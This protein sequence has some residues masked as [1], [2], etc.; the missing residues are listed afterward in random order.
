MFINHLSAETTKSVAFLMIFLATVMAKNT[1]I[2]AVDLTPVSSRQTLFK[3]QAWIVRVFH[4]FIDR[5]GKVAVKVIKTDKS[6]FY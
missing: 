1:K 6:V 3:Y 2:K 4:F 5:R